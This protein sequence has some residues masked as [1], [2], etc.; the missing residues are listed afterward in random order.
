MHRSDRQAAERHSESATTERDK[1]VAVTISRE[2]QD[3]LSA[4]DVALRSSE[5]PT[6]RNNCATWP[7]TGGRLAALFSRDPNGRKRENV[8][9]RVHEEVQRLMQFAERARQVENV[10]CAGDGSVRDQRGRR[11]GRCPD[12]VSAGPLFERQ[13][14]GDLRRTLVQA[15]PDVER[16]K[17]VAGHVSPRGSWRLWA[18]P[19]D[20]ARQTERAAR[21]LVPRLRAERV[22]G[23]PEPRRRR[24]SPSL[25]QITQKTPRDERSHRPQILFC[26][27]ALKRRESL[28]VCRSDTAH[29]FTPQ[30]DSHPPTTSVKHQGA[31]I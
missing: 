15:R 23:Y 3:R 9:V 11:A 25:E 14:Y 6:G 2:E 17:T 22:M 8:S 10:T 30:S 26:L 19:G 24:G 18:L 28:A 21:K 4:D 13:E 20:A 1:W 5:A 27:C 7:T 29:A 16:E 12:P 31:A